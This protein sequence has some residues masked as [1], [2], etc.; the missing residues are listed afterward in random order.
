MGN[1]IQLAIILTILFGLSLLAGIAWQWFTPGEWFKCPLEG[2]CLPYFYLWTTYNPQLPSYTVNSPEAVTAIVWDYR[3][4]DTLFETSVFYLALVAGIA[5]ARGIR[6]R[7]PSGGDRGL[8]V[9]VKTVSK[10]TLPMIITVGASIGLHGHLTPGG[11][12]QGGATAAVAPMVAIIVFSVAFLVERGLSKENMLVLRSIGL[13]GIGLT[14][15]LLFFVGLLYGV[16]A[17]VFQNMA[18][19]FSPVS[20]P[21]EVN[22]ALISGTLWFFNLFEFIAVT[23]GFTIAFML[24]AMPEDSVEGGSGE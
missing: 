22:G 8:S 23:A 20:F 19:P 4:L 9:I 12:F 14:A 7:L 2:I 18:K 17:Y 11:G 15:V 5:L 16:N 13:T 10:L 1:L 24:L 6:Y 21:W 3:G